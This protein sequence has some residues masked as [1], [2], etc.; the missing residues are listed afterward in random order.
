MTEHESSLPDEIQN[1]LKASEERE[2]LEAE[3]KPEQQRDAYEIQERVTAILELREAINGLEGIVSREESSLRSYVYTRMTRG[4]GNFEVLLPENCDVT[5]FPLGDVYKA[6]AESFT[7][8]FAEP[9]GKWGVDFINRDRT[10]YV[11]V[12]STDFQVIPVVE[13]LTDQEADT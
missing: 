8:A 10:A 6:G 1:A 5:E 7:A 12:Q 3:V 9:A 2:T 11:R 13:K 4:L